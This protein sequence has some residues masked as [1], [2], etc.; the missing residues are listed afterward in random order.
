MNTEETAIKLYHEEHNKVQHL[1]SALGKAKEKIFEMKEVFDQV[2]SPPFLHGTVLEIHDTVTMATDKGIMEVN[3]PLP[4]MEIK[5]GDIMSLQADTMQIID[6]IKSEPIGETAILL[7]VINERQSEVEYASGSKVVYSGEDHAKKLAKGDKIVLDHTTSIILSNLGKED[8]TFILDQGFKGVEWDDIGGLEHAKAELIEAI[9]TP[10]KNPDIFKF[11]NK[12]PPKGV[13]L[14]GPPGCGKTMLGKATAASIAKTF[15]QVNKQGF[16][17]VKGPEILNRYVGVTEAIIRQLFGRCQQF[18][19]ENGFP[20][21]LFIDEADAILNKRGSRTSS[22][23]DRTIVPMFLAEMDGLA[24]SGAIVMLVTNRPDTLDP[25]V[26]REGRIDIKIR[27]GRPTM[28]NAACI[29]KLYLDKVPLAKGLDQRKLSFQS[30][31][32]IFA[33]EHVIYHIDTKEGT[34]NLLLGHIISGSMIASVVDKA[35]SLA[36]RRDL[37]TNSRRGITHDD[38]MVSIKDTVCQNRATDH[39]AELEDF[40]KDFKKDVLSVRVGG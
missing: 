38:I 25:A 29:F 16:I 5:P 22:D 24:E 31:E 32:A 28:E 33:E 35:T 20:A 8:N 21:V 7:R 6:H 39:K 11:Y 26:V 4:G 3:L 27:V 12:R 19:E 1:E 18:K 17:Y 15:K 13:L 30:T 36:L 2:M 10:F 14:H 34:R 9:E 23:I 37:D 40:I